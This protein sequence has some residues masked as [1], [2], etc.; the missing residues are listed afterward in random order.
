MPNRSNNNGTENVTENTYQ[1]KKPHHIAGKFDL[2]CYCH[3]PL[4]VDKETLAGISKVCYEANSDS[5]ASYRF[6][7]VLKNW[8][9]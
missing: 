2:D 6:F 1:H 4:L 7:I 8:L 5:C 9:L 3:G